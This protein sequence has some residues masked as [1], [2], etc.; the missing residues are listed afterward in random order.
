MLGLQDKARA[1]L[2]DFR[3]GKLSLGARQMSPETPS[4]DGDELDTLGGRTRLVAR[5]ISSGSPP[6]MDRSPTTLHPIIP[7]PLGPT[8]DN[9]YHPSVVEYLRT[10]AAPQ[11]TSEPETAVIPNSTQSTTYSDSS[12]YGLTTIPLSHAA[13]CN[14]PSTLQQHLQPFSQSPQDSTSYR[15]MNDAGSFP[16]YFPVYDYASTVQPTGYGPMQMESDTPP[17]N[18]P[19]ANMH[20]TWQDFVAGLGMN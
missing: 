4:D 14:R 13:N 8:Y 11:M 3:K 1:T 5:K 7:L 16:Q 15:P 12:L 17:M 20:T 19:E 9:Q 6:L 2:S 18:S 10:F